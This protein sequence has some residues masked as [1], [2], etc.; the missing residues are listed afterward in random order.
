MNFTF[1]KATQEVAFFRSDAEQAEWTQEEMSLLCTFPTIQ[2]KHVQRG[3]TILFQDPAI[4]DWHAY[5]VRNAKFIEGDHYQQVRAESIAISELTDCHIRDDIELTNVAPADALTRV[6]QGTGWIVGQVQVTSLSSGDVYR[7]DVWSAINSIKQN[8]NCYIEPRVTVNADGIAERVLDI[9]SPEGAWR[10]LRL[11][12]DKNI[13]DS[14]VTYDDT[15]LYTAFYGYGSTY[16][17]SDET[18]EQKTTVFDEISWE[19][20]DSHPAKPAGQGYIEDPEKTALYGRNGRPRFGYYQNSDIKDPA[21]LLEKT[22]ES[23][24]KH[25]EPRVSISGTVADLYRLG[26]KDQPLR[27]HDM[28]IVE[29]EPIGV[30]LYKQIIRLTVDL[31][32]ATRNTPEIGD[33]IPNII[34]INREIEDYATDGG[35]SSGGGGSRA[36]QKNSEFQT[37]ID[38][39][40]RNI[41]LNARHIDNHGN[42]L[43]QAGMYID[44]ITGV[45]IYAEDNENMVGSRFHVMSDRISTEVTDR[46]NADNVL[47]SRITQTADAISLEVSERK[48]GEAVLSSR[49]TVEANR[50]TQ[51]VTDRTNADS[52]L[53]SRITQ[54]ADAITAEVTRATDAEGTLSGRITVEADRITTEVSERTSADT[55]LSSRITQTSDAIT[56]EVTRATS[57]EGTLSGRIQVNSDK[58]SV[59]VEEKD[60][61]NVVKAA[62]IVAGIN[63]QTGSYVKIQADTINLSGY[64]TASD[65]AATNA[66]I[67]NLKTGQSTAVELRSGRMYGGTV[68]INTGGWTNVDAA[69]KDVNLSYVQSTGTLTVELTRFNG[70]TV[71]DSVTLPT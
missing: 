37:S 57:A 52:N 32:D 20:T 5:E 9:I 23:L 17:V 18:D 28:A 56:A 38:R 40:E 54:T 45:L 14:S 25:Y 39:D 1:L 50:I 6:L 34:Y 33:Y 2:G 55:A 61:R 66:S 30:L 10:G 69:F 49:I 22:W 11:A 48:S 60:G 3:M 24:K 42:I 16:T 19:K 8:W 51:E 4:G 31:L 44:P 7:G 68:Y 65:L 36:K 67:D 70:S 43:Q 63:G 46:K 26:Y 41:H 64:V 58:V 62:S 13:S 29:V 59:V 47:S 12:I 71:S 27:L 21:V 35:K 15:E 53:S